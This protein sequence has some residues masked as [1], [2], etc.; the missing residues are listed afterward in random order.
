MSQKIRHEYLVV[1]SCHCVNR[2]KIKNQKVRNDVKVL[3]A[4]YSLISLV[5]FGIDKSLYAVSNFKVQITQLVMKHKQTFLHFCG[6]DG[7]ISSINLFS[8]ETMPL[9][10]TSVFSS[11]ISHF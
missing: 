8:D 2:V 5:N 1:L 7:Y 6:L 10:A 3:E 9:Q 4:Y 11:L